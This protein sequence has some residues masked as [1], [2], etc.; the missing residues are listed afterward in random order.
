[1]NIRKFFQKFTVLFSIIFMFSLTT[2]LFMPEYTFAADPPSEDPPTSDTEDPDDP[3]APTGGG[4]CVNLLGF[5]SWNCY[6][7]TDNIDS[8]SDLSDVIWGIVANVSVDLIVAAGYLVLGYVIYGGY[9]YIFSAGDPG[10]AATGKKAIYQAFVGLAITLSSYVI[11]T[12]IRTA[13]G[14]VSLANCLRANP[15][16]TFNSDGCGADNTPEIV[17]KAIQYVVGIAGAISLIFV[18]Y[19]A[20]QYITSAG[21]AGKVQKAKNLIMYSLI[22]LA[23]VAVAEIATSFISQQIREASGLSMIVQNPSIATTLIEEKI[24][25]IN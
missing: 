4:D 16:G 14:N 22:G 1:M 21:D 17:T 11:L 15:D 2:L 12:A 20:I 8:T 19:G 5:V 6:I 7:N 23:I 18:I 9:L 10:K 3:D 24:N 25:E 13:L